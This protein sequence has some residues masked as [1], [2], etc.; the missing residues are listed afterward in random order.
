[1]LGDQASAL[2]QLVMESAGRR[3]R[4]VAVTSGKG[5]VGKSSVAV[6][7]AVRLSGMGRRV[8]LLD[9]DLGTANAD[10]LCN[11]AARTN[12]AHVVAGR[13]T[14]SEAMV[15][16]PGG[17]R[18]VPGASGL[19]TIADL[20]AFERARLIQAMQE[21]DETCDVVLVD[22]GAGIGP[23]VL[24]FALGVDQVLVVTTPEP[25]AVTDA[26]ALIKSVHRQ[27]SDANVSV[28]VNLVHSEGEARQVFERVNG[29]CRRFLQLNLTFAGHMP[30][31]EQVVVGAMRR[32]PFVLGAP[33][34]DASR[35][36]GCLAHKLDRHASEP[37]GTG[38]LGRMVNWLA[39]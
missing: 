18:L 23:N 16:A 26:Y 33:H 37:R 27:R 28:F 3:A 29:V 5:G 9:A 21:I 36:I 1:M 38:L 35:S 20:S 10:V 12:L 19:A 4:Y 7:L 31:D 11:V 39:G 32:W 25:S 6:N 13:R 8:V 34:S 2:R 17:F 30:R 14:L 24:G 22:T 15:A